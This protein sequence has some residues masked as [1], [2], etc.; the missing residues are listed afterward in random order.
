[1]RQ[2]S[3]FVSVKNSVLNAGFP[4]FLYLPGFY[5]ILILSENGGSML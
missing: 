2:Y 3:F 4:L 1:M 5:A